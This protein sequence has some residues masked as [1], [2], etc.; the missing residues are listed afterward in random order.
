MYELKV[1]GEFSGAHRLRNYKGKCEN[2]H[3]HNWKVEI[4]ITGEYLDK[5]G[6]LLDFGILKE[7]LDTVL[8]QLD[9]KNLNTIPFFRRT[10]PSSENISYYIFTKMKILL[11]NFPVRLKKVTVW[12]NDRQCASYSE[13]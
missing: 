3:G 7:K 2:L 1:K 5:T 12:E 4:V 6:L 8:K 9:H 10:N 13:E 11:K